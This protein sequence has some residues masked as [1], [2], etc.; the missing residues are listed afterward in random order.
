MSKI[1]NWLF[2]NK[3]S[4]N[5][6][7]TKFMLIHSKRSCPTLNLYIKNNKIEQVKS[8]EYLGTIMDDKVNWCKQIKHVESKLSQACGAIARIRPFCRSG[9]HPNTV[10]WSCLLIFRIFCTGLGVCSKIESKKN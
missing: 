1:E 4:L 3:L 9:M 10:F 8:Y 5:Y 2:S 6:S 7:K